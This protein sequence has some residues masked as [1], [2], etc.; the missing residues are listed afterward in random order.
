MIDSAPPKERKKYH[1]HPRFK[2]CPQPGQ[3]YSVCGQSCGQAQNAKIKSTRKV[4]QS[5]NSLS[6]LDNFEREGGGDYRTRICGPDRKSCVK[7][8]K[9][10]SRKQEQVEGAPN[11]TK[12]DSTG[13]THLCSG[14]G[15]GMHAQ[16]ECCLSSRKDYTSFS[17]SGAAVV[18]ISHITAAFISILL[19][20]IFAS[21]SPLH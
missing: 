10:Q 5:K 11:R 12:P 18:G 4:L 21:C 20:R 2:P 7:A 17:L 16:P 8:D 14:M 9:R 6:K 1:A 13:Y 19:M 3:G 15:D